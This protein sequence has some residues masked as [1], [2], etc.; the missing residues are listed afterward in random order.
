MVH[1]LNHEASLG[2]LQAMVQMVIAALSV[3][4]Q[5]CQ[6]SAL[7]GGQFSQDFRSNRASSDDATLTHTTSTNPKASTMICRFGPVI[8]LPPS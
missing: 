3:G 2:F 7:L 8:F 5:L 1:N 4:P 6:P